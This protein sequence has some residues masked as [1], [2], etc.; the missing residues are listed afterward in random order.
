MR[1]CGRDQQAPLL[2]VI[3]CSVRREKARGGGSPAS[4]GLAASLQTG[5]PG[6]VLRSTEPTESDP[7]S[8]TGHVAGHRESL[9]T[10]PPLPRSGASSRNASRWPQVGLAPGSGSLRPC[11]LAAW[12]IGLPH[13]LWKGGTKEAMKTTTHIV[14]KYPVPHSLILLFSL[15]H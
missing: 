4:V 15:L 12:G 2:S 10:L 9:A 5:Q 13:C 3:R 14:C 11:Q 8:R 7:G 1:A 6:S